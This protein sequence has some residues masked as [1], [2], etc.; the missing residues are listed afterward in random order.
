MAIKHIKTIK[1]I[2]RTSMH[3]SCLQTATKT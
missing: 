2:N 1:I 3:M